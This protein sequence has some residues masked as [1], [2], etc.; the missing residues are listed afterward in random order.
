MKS[1]LFLIYVYRFFNFTFISSI[2]LK[3]SEVKW[4]LV[5]TSS[6]TILKSKKSKFFWPI[7][8]YCSKNGIIIFI[9]SENF[10]I[11]KLTVLSLKEV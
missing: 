7:M 8:G 9:I 2:F 3:P 10:E 5:L 1:W 4:D 11:C 6:E